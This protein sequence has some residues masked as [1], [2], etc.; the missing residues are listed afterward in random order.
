MT[1]YLELGDVMD[2]FKKLADDI[3]GHIFMTYKTPI[4]EFEYSPDGIIGWWPS[5]RSGG[6]F[7]YP[8]HG[9]AILIKT[10]EMITN[11]KLRH[12]SDEITSDT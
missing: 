8:S 1:G 10:W 7:K 3:D 9:D 12:Q 4:D 6:D 5:A 11:E 2:Q